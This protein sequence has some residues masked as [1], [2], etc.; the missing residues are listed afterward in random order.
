MVSKSI[1]LKPNDLVT[2]SLILEESYIMSGISCKLTLADDKIP[3]I[4]YQQ[5]IELS[6]DIIHT[7][8]LPENAPRPK[9]LKQLG[10]DIEGDE[11]NKPILVTIPRYISSVEPGVNG[12]GFIQP[13]EY[14]ELKINRYSLI[15]INWDY[16]YPDK[17]FQV[18]AVNSNMINPTF[19][20]LK[21]IPYRARVEVDPTPLNDVNLTQLKI[22]EQFQ[23]LNI[24]R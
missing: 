15:E 17:I 22:E 14:Y 11:N 19:F 7:F 9:L 23:H 24:P 2:N 16:D 20:Y 6:E 5:N 21:L 1:L 10:W 4:G 3:D 13:I 8:I 12:T 18:T